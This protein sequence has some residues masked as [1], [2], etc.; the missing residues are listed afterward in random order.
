MN[1]QKFDEY[2]DVA[3]VVS[4]ILAVGSWLIVIIMMILGVL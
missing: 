3:L 4:G 2:L 1:W